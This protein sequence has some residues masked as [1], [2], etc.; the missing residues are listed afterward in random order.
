[1]L[2]L[3]PRASRTKNF[4]LVEAA[5]LFGELP[6]QIP[7]TTKIPSAHLAHALRTVASLDLD[8]VI[9]VALSQLHRQVRDLCFHQRGRFE[10]QHKLEVARAAARPIVQSRS[11]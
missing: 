4:A 7:Q 8:R 1:M 3:L 6:S 2:Q 9:Y 10:S 5:F 11:G